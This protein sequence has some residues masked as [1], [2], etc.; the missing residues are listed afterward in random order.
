MS[1]LSALSAYVHKIHNAGVAARFDE[2][3]ASFD[4]NVAIDYAIRML[5]PARSKHEVKMKRLALKDKKVLVT[6]PQQQPSPSAH[7]PRSL[8]KA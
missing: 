1:A 4:D 3:R 2:L 7:L 6:A 8:Q 5:G